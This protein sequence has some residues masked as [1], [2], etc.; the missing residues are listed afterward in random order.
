MSRG[1]PDRGGEDF[2]RRRRASG[3]DVPAQLSDGSTTRISFMALREF[4]FITK[5]PTGWY[6]STLLNKLSVPATV[7]G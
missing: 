3:R 4:I 7:I 1:H 2:G 5:H 6:E